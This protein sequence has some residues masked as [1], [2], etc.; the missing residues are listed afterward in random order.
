MQQSHISNVI[1]RLDK[2]SF[3]FDPLTGSLISVPSNIE[4]QE[5]HN[6]HNTNFD[7]HITGSIVMVPRLKDNV[8]K[9]SLTG[10]DIVNTHS[11]E[12]TFVSDQ[13]FRSGV[14][15]FELNHVADFKNIKF[16][17]LRFEG[18]DEKE[19]ISISSTELSHSAIVKVD[20]EDLKLVGIMKNS[21]KKQVKELKHGEYKL[22]VTIKNIGNFLSLNPFS[23]PKNTNNVWSVNLGL[24][25][26]ENLK[27]LNMWYIVEN[28]DTTVFD[29]LINT[30]ELINTQ[31]ENQE[32]PYLYDQETKIFAICKTEKLEALLKEKS[33]TLEFLKLDHIHLAYNIAIKES[34]TQNGGISSLLYKFMKDN[35]AVLLSEARNVDLNKIV[36]II[37]QIRVYNNAKLLE[38]SDNLGE[39]HITAIPFENSNRLVLTNGHNKIKLLADR[40]SDNKFIISPYVFEDNKVSFYLTPEEHQYLF[41]KVDIQKMV[42]RLKPN[43]SN[44]NALNAFFSDLSSPSNLSRTNSTVFYRVGHN[45]LKVFIQQMFAYI[46]TFI[47]M[48]IQK[49][50]EV[51]GQAQNHTG[52]EESKEEALESVQDLFHEELSDKNKKISTD[53]TLK[54]FKRI[55]NTRFEEFPTDFDATLSILFKLE[56][57]LYLQ[58]QDYRNIAVMGSRNHSAF[59]R[60]FTYVRI[61]NPSIDIQTLVDFGLYVNS[62]F[63]NEFKH[64]QDTYT[65]ADNFSSAN[66]SFSTL[67]DML[68]STNNKHFNGCFNDNIHLKYSLNNL[69]AFKFSSAIEYAGLA[70]DNYLTVVTEDKLLRLFAVKFGLIKLG[71]IDLKK[72]FNWSEKKLFESIAKDEFDKNQYFTLEEVFEKQAEEQKSEIVEQDIKI[73]KDM[74]EQ[75]YKMGFSIELCKKAL[76]K[77]KSVSLDAA[78]NVI[79]DLTAED[80]VKDEKKVEY[81]LVLKPQWQ[82]IICTYIN[83]IMN[84][85][86]DSQNVCDMC[87]NIAN[88]EAYFQKQS[89]SPDRVVN[90]DEIILRSDVKVDVNDKV[91]DC[92]FVELQKENL[93]NGKFLIMKV[94]KQDQNHIII[95]RLAINEDVIRKCLLLNSKSGQFAN[96]FG[97]ALLKKTMEENDF[98]ET[99]HSDHYDQFHYLLPYMLDGDILVESNRQTIKLE[100]N[101]ALVDYAVDDATFINARNSECISVILYAQG[102]TSAKLLE[103]NLINKAKNYSMNSFDFEKIKQADIQDFHA[104]E[105]VGNGIIAANGSGVYVSLPKSVELK[106]IH[107]LKNNLLGLRVV[108]NAKVLVAVDQNKVEE[109]SID[110]LRLKQKDVLDFIQ[111][112]DFNKEDHNKMETSKFTNPRSLLNNLKTQINIKSTAK[113]ISNALINSLENFKHFI[114]SLDNTKTSE[115]SFDLEID[116]QLVNAKVDFYLKVPLES[117]LAK[118]LINFKTEKYPN[119][120]NQSPTTIASRLPLKAINN[121]E[122]R[123]SRAH[124]V[125]QMLIDD[126]AYYATKNPNTLFIFENVYEKNM[127]VKKVLLRIPSTTNFQQAVN[128]DKYLVFVFNSL[129]QANSIIKYKNLN[130]HHYNHMK[131]YKTFW[132]NCEP[133]CYIDLSTSSNGQVEIELNS[134]VSGRYIGLLPLCSS[135]ADKLNTISMFEYFGIEGTYIN[136]YDETGSTDDNA[137]S[138]LK[139][140]KFNL[141]GCQFSYHTHI[142]EVKDLS[143]LSFEERDTY[144]TVKAVAKATLQELYA[145]TFQFSFK[146]QQENNVTVM[147]VRVRMSGVYNTKILEIRNDFNQGN[148]SVLSTLIPQYTS[149]ILLNKEHTDVQEKCDVIDFLVFLMNVYGA[150]ISATIQ[151]NLNIEQLFQNEVLKTTDSDLIVAYNYFLS[152]IL[153]LDEASTLSKKLILNTINKLTDLEVT[154]NGLVLFWK[155]VKIEFGS[156]ID[157]E[158]YKTLVNHFKKVV[159]KIIELNSAQNKVM[160]CFGFVESLN[161]LSDFTNMLSLQNTSSKQNTN[162]TSQVHQ[163]V[164][165]QIVINDNSFTVSENNY[166]EIIVNC[167][168][169][170]ILREL[171]LRVKNVTKI[172]SFTIEVRNFDFKTRSFKLIHRKI[173]NEDFAHYLITK[174]TALKPSTD[175]DFGLNFSDTKLLSKLLKITINFNYIPIFDFASNL[176]KIEFE[177]LISGLKVSDVEAL[178]LY[179]QEMDDFAKEANI[180]FIRMLDS[181]TLNPIY[182][183]LVKTKELDPYFVEN[184]QKAEILVTKVPET[185]TEVDNQKQLNNLKVKTACEDLT[186]DKNTLESYINSLDILELENREKVITKISELLVSY[187][188]NINHLAE[189]QSC[190]PASFRNYDKNITFWMLNLNSIISIFNSNEQM[191]KMLTTDAEYENIFTVFFYDVFVFSNYKD[192]NLAQF[193][194]KLI[195]ESTKEQTQKII[196]VLISKNLNES[197]M[198]FMLSNPVLLEKLELLKYSSAFNWKELMEKLIELSRDFD[199]DNN[200]NLKVLLTYSKLFNSVLKISN[201]DNDLDIDNFNNLIYLLNWIIENDVQS[202]AAVYEDLIGQCIDR[203]FSI[204]SSDNN[205]FEVNVD[206]LQKLFLNVNNCGFEKLLTNALNNFRVS[207]VNKF[208]KAMNDNKKKSL[209][210]VRDILF[211]IVK[212]N[213]IN[214]SNESKQ[215]D[216]SQKNE[217][218]L[219]FC[220]THL[221]MINDLIARINNETQ[222][223]QAK[224]SKVDSVKRADSLHRPSSSHINTI[225]VNKDENTANNFILE[226]ISFVQSNNLESER[227]IQL[228]I[229]FVFTDNLS[230]N[231][232]FAFVDYAIKRDVNIRKSIILQ[233]IESLTPIADAVKKNSSN[234]QKNNLKEFGT[235][236][237][238]LQLYFLKNYK[239]LLLDTHIYSDLCY[240]LVCQIINYEN[241]V[242]YNEL[243]KVPIRA[244][245]FAD[246][247]LTTFKILIEEFNFGGILNFQF[248]S[249]NKLPLLEILSMNLY[250]LTKG[251]ENDHN[252]LLASFVQNFRSHADILGEDVMIQA[253]DN[254]TTWYVYNYC[255]ISVP[256]MKSISGVLYKKII[257]S[258]HELFIALF[259]KEEIAKIMLNAFANRIKSLHNVIGS[260]VEAKTL[261]FQALYSTENALEMFENIIN[262]VI[263][264]E[265]LTK[266][267]LSQNKGLELI[268][269]VLKHD[270]LSNTKSLKAESKV[271]TLADKLKILNSKKQTNTDSA[272]KAQPTIQRSVVKEEQNMYLEYGNKIKYIQL[273]KSVTNANNIKDW[274]ANKV[275]RNATIY[276]TTLPQHK[277][278]LLMQFKFNE[279]IELRD[280]K[281]GITVSRTENYLM[282]G[283]PSF[284][285]LY[286]LYEEPNQ[287]TKKVFFGDLDHIVD[288]GYL[289]Y[290]TQVYVLNPNKLSHTNPETAI[291]DLVYLRKMSGIELVIGKPLFSVVEKIS[292]SHTKTLNQINLSINFLSI[293]GFDSDS[294]NISETYNSLIQSS[295]HKFIKI[296]FNAEDI[297]NLID[298]YFDDLNKSQDVALFDMI[299]NELDSI[300]ANFDL[301]MSRF[302]LI[303]SEKNKKLANV[304]FRFLMKN[305][306]KNDIFYSLIENILK[307]TRSYTFFNEFFLYGVEKFFAEKDFGSRFLEVISNYISHL[308]K[309]LES[310]ADNKFIIPLTNEFF[311]EVLR[312]YKVFKLNYNIERFVLLVLYYSQEGRLYTKCDK[313]GYSTND[314]VIEAKYFTQ[315]NKKLSK[316]FIHQ[317]CSLVVEKEDYSYLQL[318]GYA[319]LKILEVKNVIVNSNLIDNIIQH[320][321]KEETDA[322]ETEMLLFVQTISNFK[323]IHLVIIEKNLHKVLIELLK[324]KITQAAFKDNENS[325]NLLLKALFDIYKISSEKIAELE[326]VLFKLLKEHNNDSFFIQNVLMKLFDFELT[327]YVHFIKAENKL[328]M[329]NKKLD[330]REEIIEEKGFDDALKIK[331]D[332]L[333][334][335]W[336]NSLSQNLVH[337]VDEKV[338]KDFVSYQ[339]KKIATFDGASD[340][341]P[342][343]FENKLY[344]QKPLLL[345]MHCDVQESTGILGMYTPLS[346]IKFENSNTEYTAYVP[347]SDNTFIFFYSNENQISHFKVNQSH[348]EKFLHFTNTSS[349]KSLQFIYEEQEKIFI[350]FTDG[351]E[352]NTIDL[353]P[354]TPVSTDPVPSKEFPYDVRLR[355]L[356]IHQLQ[357]QVNKDASEKKDLFYESLKAMTNTDSIF[358]ALY[359]YYYTEPIY[360]LPEELTVAQIENSLRVEVVNKARKNQKLGDIHDTLINLFVD[361]EIRTA[362]KANFENNYN[363]N[364]PVFE[365]FL[366]KG[367]M[368]YVIEVIMEK[369]IAFLKPDEKHRWQQIMQNLIELQKIEGFLSSMI[370][371]KN[372]LLTIFELFIGNKESTRDW[373]EAEMTI[374]SLIF[375][376]LANILK[377]SVSYEVRADFLNKNVLKMLLN[378]LHSLTNEISRVYSDEDHVE[379]IISEVVIKKEP[380][381]KEIKKRKGVGYD[382]EGSGKKWLVNE[383]FAKKKVR[384]EFMVHLLKL[385]NNLFSIQFPSND[386]PENME[387]RNSLFNTICESCMLPLLES[388]FKSSSLYEM[389]KEFEL[390]EQY[391]QSL[392]TISRT[393]EIKALVK[394]I[395]KTYKP[396]QLESLISIVK[397]QE[398]NTS[399]FMNLSKPENKDEAD[400]ATKSIELAEIILDTI[401]KIKE[402]YPEEF[403]E[404]TDEVPEMSEADIERINNMGVNEKYKLSLKDFRFDVVDMANGDSSGY[405]HHY[406]SNIQSDAKNTSG[407]R[408][409]RLAQEIADLSSSLPIDSYNAIFV[410]SDTNR[411]DVVK[412]MIS[413]AEATPYANGLFEYHVYL[414]SDYP[415]SP[416]KCNLETTG[417]GDVRFNPNLYACGKVCLSLLGTWR[418]NA[419]ENWDPKISNLLQLYLSIQSVVMSEEVYFNE[420]GYE[421]EAGTETGEAKNEG[422]S[423]IVRLCN[424]KY[425][426][427]KQIKEPVKG[428]EE[429]TRRHFY[430]K[431]DVILSEVGS[432]IKMAEVRP[433]NYS[434]LVSDHNHKYASTYNANRAAYIT[435]LKEEIKKLETALKELVLNNEIETV[436]A[437][438]RNEKQKKRVKKA[439]DTE[440]TVTDKEL[441]TIKEGID[442]TYEDIINE[443]EFNAEDATVAD[444]WSRYIGAMGIEA[445]KKQSKAKVAVIGMNN[446]G[447]EVSK[448]IILSGVNKIWLCDW[449]KLHMKDLLGNFYASE[450]DIGQ[451]RAEIVKSKLQQLN[452]YVKVESKT[453][454]QEEDY[455][456]LDECDII[457]ITDNY[458]PMTNK[459]IEKAKQLQKKLI[460]AD[461]V[462]VYC[463][464]FCDFGDEFVVTDRDG[465]E[466][467]ECFI[468]DIN[469]EKNIIELYPNSVHDMQVGDCIVLSEVTTKEDES[470]TEAKP[471]NNAVLKIKDFIKKN[472]ILV[473]EDLKIFKQFERNGKVKQMKLPE[474]LSFKR[475]DAL[476]EEDVFDA[477]LRIHD[478][479]KMTSMELISKC[480]IIKEKY[481]KEALTRL[482][483]HAKLDLSKYTSENSDESLVS[484]WNKFTL[485]T[486]GNVHSINAF[487][488]GLV[489]QEIIKGITNKFKPINQLFCTDFEELLE[490]G[491]KNPETVVPLV[492]NIEDKYQP[493]SFLLGKDLVEKIKDAKLFMVGAGAIG[494]ELLKNYSMIGL[495]INGQITLTDPDSIELSNLSRQFLFREKHIGKPKSL[496]AAKVVETMNTDYVDKTLN[497]R[498]DKVHE[499]SEDVFTDQ[500]FKSQTLCTNALDN[501]KARIYMDQRCVRNSIPLLESGTL[502]PKGHVQVILPFITENYGQVQDASAE[503]N[504]PICTLKMFPEEGIH[505]MEWA[506]DRFEYLFGQNPKSFLRV[507]EEYKRGG[508]ISSLDGKVLKKAV[509]FLKKRPTDFGFCVELARK[510][511]Q[512]YFHDNIKQLLH[513]Y[514][515]DFIT[516]DGKP[517]WTLPK[518][519]PVPIEFDLNDKLHANYLKSYSRLIARVWG[520]D[521]QI[522]KTYDFEAKLKEIVIKPFK[523]KDS[524]IESIKKAVEKEESKKDGA[525]EEETDNP[526]DTQKKIIEDQQRVEETLKLISSQNVDELATKIKD[527]IFEK[528]N[529]ANGHIDFITSMCNL[530]A[531][532]YKLEEMEWI[533]V[534]LKAGRIV[535]ALAT[536]TAAVAG[537]QTIEAI[538]VI[539]QLELKD[540]RNAFINLAIPYMT[541][542]EPGPVSKYKIHDDLTVTVWD[543]W[544]YEF[545]HGKGDK[546]SDL[547]E[548][549]KHTYKIEPI[550]M[551]RG[552]KA[553]FFSAI[554]K[555]EEY[556]KKKLNDLLEIEKDEDCYVTVICKLNAGDEKPLQNIPPLR[557]K[558][559]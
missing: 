202:L 306:E 549:L 129:S 545:T 163:L 399:L 304:V 461:T 204:L 311:N 292:P 500:F 208:G 6:E 66:T 175:I 331:S 43:D 245:I 490:S 484:K 17:V 486:H 395:S 269:S 258:C 11:P 187:N 92:R 558:Y 325:Q 116:Q 462:G 155:L 365:V 164:D 452:F 517:F 200:D 492:D 74:L 166:R 378:K 191:E 521:E 260:K 213:I 283:P 8:T 518:R 339:W 437:P 379:E 196:N 548:H 287:P 536:T 348:C 113:P 65:H 104:V 477:N 284:V 428:F 250:V 22:F 354:L 496:V 321:S 247:M 13:I 504:I 498:L 499:A 537:L 7:R 226:I 497:P 377:N 82:C 241:I 491:F 46:N 319:S 159:T 149:K 345:I 282:T 72:Y 125:S 47:Y 158:I 376:K 63:L 134:E 543:S 130:L 233:M 344:E 307:K 51:L 392:L 15:H 182:G 80:E 49:E 131:D 110:S 328:D 467:A 320:L 85:P 1:Q 41:S 127:R 81:A 118:T 465:E 32:K 371:N 221:K 91:Q 265:E 18:N 184:L 238:E 559:N 122:L 133:V 305:V 443:K 340:S 503:H 106:L 525:N 472:E 280:L 420:P 210:I 199:F 296:L 366:T 343:D 236:L 219:T 232:L 390:Y 36:S 555:Y 185:Q 326:D 448:N 151:E 19:E 442:I 512:K 391:C 120:V 84:M 410:R 55:F 271:K 288:S 506:K 276:S 37:D 161:G 61:A 256:E 531:T 220:L 352:H 451:H 140:E 27:R 417:S 409:I 398:T 425:A 546:L 554:N 435:D 216:L 152:K 358:S 188:K 372:F 97:L 230:K 275:G 100:E 509:A 183:P 5:Q 68:S 523:P 400:E 350:S 310:Q 23:L 214:L 4:L 218:L 419:S 246:L 423:N 215:V 198:V 277:K 508:D 542:S 439:K 273:D 351:D 167:S 460:I 143:I 242:G 360:S 237:I 383:Y 510:A 88:D 224:P 356:E 109:V 103:Y 243:C 315:D 102:D 440:N 174:N 303:V 157:D 252:K 362:V 121:K 387:I 519:P 222:E 368:K 501:V 539:K 33:F 401:N 327:K 294:I 56:E 337:L 369:D 177:H 481:E 212:S 20:L 476:Y 291:Q 189:N 87:G 541:L 302:L 267:F 453:M 73:N 195:S 108:G 322:H 381:V 408:M 540:Y 170:H 290:S 434:G 203:V 270:Q 128:L 386:T 79:F 263:G 526:E 94:K 349:Q 171:F 538:K 217:Q 441:F 193:I 253:L 59:S 446:L 301:K 35:A 550:D 148:F 464:V 34:H 139:L 54:K 384:N 286:G 436:F 314:C 21:F 251:V 26:E 197:D 150:K 30:F 234:K 502:G 324:R 223:L 471:L 293:N 119:V 297:A 228:L 402:A 412:V 522:W 28:I 83:E 482:N 58:S 422:Y 466:P 93:L 389:A 429:V 505:C 299:E 9:A 374:S 60:L 411:L 375:E 14:H 338:K 318:L 355:T 341:L 457:L 255:S 153:S 44:L 535:P 52:A 487:M 209:D 62:A 278:Y 67:Y 414:P 285:Q 211:N 334:K 333:K 396:Q 475:Y 205:S 279:P 207:I 488:G 551:F 206:N 534:K 186:N 308:A 507:I 254:L 295:Y 394:P 415:N 483:A 493:L 162:S 239:D 479:E 107:E 112:T 313:Q 433:C 342:P 272:V 520:L 168:E 424:I 404:D 447:L 427:L 76:K 10:I 470:N 397:K 154:S 240:F 132:K 249:A 274:T 225:P 25:D 123:F 388:A 514:P 95:S 416:P 298:S 192:N 444:R 406:V 142:V 357:V 201:L 266:H 346:F 69:P 179:S 317:I 145:K 529:D 75:M 70:S 229:E 430:I 474:K 456:F 449:E 12:C 309:Y 359:S 533:N 530:R 413:G 312:R 329:S 405:I 268:F 99:L 469:S 261:G 347:N 180:K 3:E 445:V 335:D 353:Y 178:S 78:I 478:F 98:S 553:I 373:S 455:S 146:S 532:N 473:E 316:D 432:W 235:M 117:N 31:T 363:P 364:F 24:L 463:R 380:I 485:N 438:K 45:S 459:A 172:A 156:K 323:D 552:N 231:V 86:K 147:G 248:I 332:Y 160:R 138:T 370:Q 194:N 2:T 50:N 96:V 480:F 40:D 244:S 426:M 468:K 89:T 513:I 495:G 524:V 336:M 137:E 330:V 262:M 556:A 42:E 53:L 450:K 418:G 382:K 114:I 407:S 227:I 190:I 547:Y 281:L 393:D 57:A 29:E 431:R 77:V 165:K 111:E 361:K 141:Q 527:E 135:N 489:S 90:K 421:G 136:R 511:F 38:T 144:L 181:L 259:A 289:V 115:L 515:L 458:L 48:H 16:G 454:T 71:E 528:D 101:L 385:F 557:I 264:N 494:C 176:D 403:P 39:K 367:G 105:H 544:T 124:H 300:I 516:K 169:V 64:Y 257:T 126:S 173:F